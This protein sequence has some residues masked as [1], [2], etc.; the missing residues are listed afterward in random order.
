MKGKLNWCLVSTAICT[1]QFH[2]IDDELKEI[3]RVR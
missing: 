2:D 1:D 3:R